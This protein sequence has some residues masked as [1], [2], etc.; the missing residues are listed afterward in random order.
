MP[1]IL[2]RGSY[3]MILVD[4][5]VLLLDSAVCLWFALVNRPLG[6]FLPASMIGLI[7]VMLLLLVRQARR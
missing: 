1:M 5:G 7:A 4:L 2:D 3:R 6:W